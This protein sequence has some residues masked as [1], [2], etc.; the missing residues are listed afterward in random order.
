MKET[1]AAWERMVRERCQEGEKKR[2]R[3]RRRKGSKV[4]GKEE[5]RNE[6]EAEK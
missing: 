2:R 3:W 1:R 4:K 6:R 5:E